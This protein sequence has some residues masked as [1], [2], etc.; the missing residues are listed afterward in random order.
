M[1][2]GYCELN[3]APPRY[4]LLRQKRK[5]LFLK[6]CIPASCAF[7]FQLETEVLNRTKGKLRTL[8]TATKIQNCYSHSDWQEGLRRRK[9]WEVHY[10]GPWPLH[11]LCQCLSVRLKSVIGKE[12]QDPKHYLDGKKLYIH[13]YNIHEVCPYWHVTAV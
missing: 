2:A 11:C 1:C 7:S 10:L 9:H 5:S 13:V 12:P 3:A 6:S 8:S 4:G